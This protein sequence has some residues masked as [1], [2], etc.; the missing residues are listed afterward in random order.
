MKLLY[1]EYIF[2]FIFYI[3]II[4]YFTAYIGII[5]SFIDNDTIIENIDVF[6]KYYISLF[7]LIRFNPLLTNNFTKYD[8]KIAF[9]SGIILF[10]STAIG[11]YINNFKKYLLHK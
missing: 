4:L 11:S 2:D 9:T 7:L 5:F 10:T 3:S 1:Q 6:M 8:K